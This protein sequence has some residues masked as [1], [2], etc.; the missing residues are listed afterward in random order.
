MPRGGRRPGAGRKPGG[1]NRKSR[2]I[3]D[4]ATAEGITPLEVMLET[5]RFHHSKGE[6]DAAAEVAARAAPYCHPRLSTIEVGGSGGPPI[7][8][9]EQLV[10]VDADRDDDAAEE[11]APSAGAIPAE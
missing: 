1:R 8:M 3:A 2:E 6:L 7:R 5:M 4:R 9:I 10:I 11:G